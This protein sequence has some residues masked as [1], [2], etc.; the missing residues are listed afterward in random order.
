M[1]GRMETALRQH[2]FLLA[3]KAS[4]ADTEIYDDV[5]I[6]KIHDHKNEYPTTMLQARYLHESSRCM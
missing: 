3:I 6:E 2:R 1:D 4:S 5:H